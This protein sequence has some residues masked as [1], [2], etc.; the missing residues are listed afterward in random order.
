MRKASKTWWAM[1]GV[2]TL[3]AAGPLWAQETRKPEASALRREPG[4]ELQDEG[5]VFR[6]LGNPKIVQELG[7]NEEQVA[8]I[9]DGAFEARKEQVKLRADI[10]LAGLEQARLLTQEPVEEKALMKAVEKAGL[11]RTEMAKL[12][13][14]QILLIRQNMT[15]AQH[16]KLRQMIGKRM[17]DW[18]KKSGSGARAGERV[19]ERRERRSSGEGE[20]NPVPP[21]FPPEAPPQP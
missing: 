1:A 4:R 20:D 10:E 15:P 21:P 2:L 12:Q 18:A 3:A 19:R 7:L 5:L 8:K 16:A 17:E 13:M 11:I 9:R 6:L 14:R